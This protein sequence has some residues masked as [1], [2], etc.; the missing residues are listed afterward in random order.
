[1][2]G[3]QVVENF[4]RGTRSVHVRVME[5]KGGVGGG[6]GGRGDGRI[7]KRGEA[8]REWGWDDGEGGE[9]EGSVKRVGV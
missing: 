9:G 1:M 5:G 3:T 2:I 8:G 7:G 6:G 4:N